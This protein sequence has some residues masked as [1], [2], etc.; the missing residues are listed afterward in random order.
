MAF[1]YLMTI[2]P[3][4]VDAKRAFSDAGEVVTK[5]RMQLNHNTIDTLCF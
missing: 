1:N 5:F 4:S 2:R 3:T